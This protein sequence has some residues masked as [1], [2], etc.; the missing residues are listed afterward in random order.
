M[1]I[2]SVCIAAHFAVS[3]NCVPS[4]GKKEK[5]IARTF[6]GGQADRYSTTKI[7]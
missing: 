3:P 5:V 1:A 7:E 6:P 4:I 2:G